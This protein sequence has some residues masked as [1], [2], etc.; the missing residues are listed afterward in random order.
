MSVDTDT[1]KTRFPEFF[2]TDDER[3]QLFIGDAVAELSESAWG[4]RYDVGICYLAAHLLAIG[5]ATELGDPSGLSPLASGGADGLSASFAKS[6]YT[7]TSQ[8]YWQSTSYGK[9]FMRL[10]RT[11]FAGARV[12]KV[13]S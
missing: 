4:T 2:E 13:E 6:A 9:E 12:A 1:F 8:E 10:K 11:L 5:I 7:N 3:V